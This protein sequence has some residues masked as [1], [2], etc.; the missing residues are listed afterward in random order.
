VNILRKLAPAAF[1]GVLV[2]GSG[3]AA[4][5]VANAGTSYSTQQTV[6]NTTLTVTWGSGPAKLGLSVYSYTQGGQEFKGTLEYNPNGGST[7]YF[8]TT[9]VCYWGHAVSVTEGASSVYMSR[10]VY[11]VS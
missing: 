8:A 5:G 3:I 1:V 2:I 9:T 10:S 7:P 4:G 11:K 6:S